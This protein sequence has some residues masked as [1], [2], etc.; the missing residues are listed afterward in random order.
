MITSSLKQLQHK[1]SFLVFL[2]S[3]H[4]LRNIYY[5][6]LVWEHFN[7]S[8]I[9]SI[10]YLISL[11]IFFTLEVYSSVTNMTGTA[12]VHVFQ[13]VLSLLLC[14]LIAAIIF[15]TL[16]SHLFSLTIPILFSPTIWTDCFIILVTKYLR[17]LFLLWWVADFYPLQF[18]FT[19]LPNLC[20][21]LPSTTLCAFLYIIIIQTS[22]F[23]I[24]Y[25]VFY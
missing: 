25:Q 8:H 19:F 3:S 23:T 15:W 7:R 14:I 22:S 17:Y 20:Y 9:S 16:Q 11:Y 13:L 4:D 21:S 2:K 10:L 1:W 12:H 6:H 24:S 5:N 18:I